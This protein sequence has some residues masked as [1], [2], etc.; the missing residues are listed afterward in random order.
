[1]KT[2]KNQRVIP[3]S[4]IV[5]TQRLYVRMFE[6]E[7][8]YIT[9]EESRKLA[10][11]QRAVEGYIEKM[12]LDDKESADEYWLILNQSLLPGTYKEICDQLRKMGYEVKSLDNSTKKEI[13]QCEKLCL[14][15]W[16]EWR[17]NRDV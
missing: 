11:Y 2:T 17:A 8:G 7:D 9:V 6:I 3:I 13:K 12:F 1:M 15:Q 5:K 10:A 4:Y 14:E 16:K